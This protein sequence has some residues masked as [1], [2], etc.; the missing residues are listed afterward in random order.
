MTS[1]AR[2]DPELWTSVLAD[3][4][5]EAA[6]IAAIGSPTSARPPWWERCGGTPVHRALVREADGHE[7]RIR[8]RTALILDRSKRHDVSRET[9]ADDRP[10]STDVS[11]ETSR[12]ALNPVSPHRPPQALHGRCRNPPNRVQIPPMKMRDDHAA[13]GDHHA[14]RVEPSLRREH[15]PRRRPLEPPQSRISPPA[16]LDTTDLESA[17]NNSTL[18][19]HLPKHQIQ[20]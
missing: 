6:R 14:G 16:D 12:S 19:A 2:H 13:F 1:P 17:A 8:E 7:P 5:V 3:V 18:P 20:E 11:R 4:S 10:S 15:R 9:P